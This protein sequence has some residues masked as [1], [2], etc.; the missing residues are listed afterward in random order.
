MPD[1]TRIAVAGFGLVGKRHAEAV[2]RL[3]ELELAAIVEPDDAARKLAA[4]LGAPCFG[5]LD[6][7]FDRVQVDG[8]ILATPTPLHVEQGL[9]IIAR[10]C[11]LLIEKP[12][13][14]TSAEALQLTS[15]AE[16]AGVPLLVGHHRRHNALVRRAKS[17]I[18]SGAI[19]QLRAVQTTCWF[20]KPDHYF[21]TAPWRTRK[22]AGPISV[23]LVHDVDLLRHFC[24]EV[25]SVQAQKAPSVRGFENEDLAA[26]LLTFRSG[27]IATI[28]VADSIAAPWSWEMTA[29]ENPAYPATNESCYLIGGTRGALSIPDLRL[30]RH[31]SVPD[32]W[33]P[34]SAT[35]LIAEAG[36]PLSLQALHFARVIRQQEPAIVSGLE[37]L[38]SLEVIEAIQLAAS[39]G[40]LVAMETPK[41]AEGSA[42]LDAATRYKR[43]ENV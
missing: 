21:E 40:Q 43:A 18:D 16:A 24:G 39:T 8:L 12:I 14:V 41:A 11:P 35:N 19:G 4:D 20:Y 13:A 26:A 10:Q 17:E 32:W 33:S 30:W 1:V 7:M 36:D 23:N 3:P 22:G 42:P 6:E 5:S 27:A 28:S 34:I 15:A 9:E 29:R 2:R 38:R 37:G 25:A 31:E